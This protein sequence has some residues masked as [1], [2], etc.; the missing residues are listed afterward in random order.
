[1]KSLSNQFEQLGQI[2]LKSNQK[3]KPNKRK[4]L[5]IKK[6]CDDKMPGQPIP[7]KPVVKRERAMELTDDLKNF[8]VKLVS[9]ELNPFC[10]LVHGLSQGYKK[11]TN[12]I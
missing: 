1:M 6:I 9:Q 2:L 10:Q 11:Q 3:N 8:K 12:I 5:V 7:I 4:K